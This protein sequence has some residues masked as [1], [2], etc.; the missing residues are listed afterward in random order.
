[1]VHKNPQIWEEHITTI[2]ITLILNL[3]LLL[4]VEKKKTLFNF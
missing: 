1:M 2:I 4:I 3:C